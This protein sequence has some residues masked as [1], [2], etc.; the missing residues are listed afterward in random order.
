MQSRRSSEG[1]S[2]AE[3]EIPIV[4]SILP[5][6]MH[7]KIA[8]FGQTMYDQWLIAVGEAIDDVNLVMAVSNFFC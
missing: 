1:S 7:A 6:G 4:L 2:N 5:K 3:S 8:I